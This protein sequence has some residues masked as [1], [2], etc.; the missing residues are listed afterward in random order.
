[1]STIKVNKIEKRT[2]STLTLGGPSTAVTLACGATQTGFG[3][4]GTVDWCTTAKTS[5]LTVESGKGYFINTTSGSVTVTLPSSPSAGDIVAFK[6][7]ANTWDS[8]SLVVCRN[9]SK[10]AGGCI[11][12]SL[13]VE[14]QSVTLIYVDATQGWKDVNDS[15]SNVQGAAFIAATGGTVTTSGNFKIH[16]FN[17]SATFCVSAVGN[18][19]GSTSV[20]YLVVA[21][22]GGGGGGAGPSSVGS[23]GGGAGGYR[24]S[25]GT[26]SGNFCTSPLGSGVSALTVAVQGYPITIGGGGTAGAYGPSAGTPG[27]DGSNSVFSTFTSAGGGGGGARLASPA[28]GRPGGSGGG[29]AFACGSGAGGTGNTPPVSPPQGQ[30]GGDQTGDGAGGGG[31]ATAAGSAGSTPTNGPGGAG[32]TSSI[33]ATPT[34]RAGGGGAGATSTVTTG[35]T[36]SDGGGAGGPASGSATAG[37]TNKGGGGGGASS[38][39]NNAGA[40]GGS[41]VVIIRYRYQ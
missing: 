38:A 17:S 2:G 23:G 1:M 28:N 41:G 39:A 29:T 11:N 10:I 22:G 6:D 25:G 35:G 27:G 15:T 7:Y 14:G 37:T 32:G 40:A 26:A 3:R 12:A 9:G 36:A 30:D 31:G 5:P 34:G 24:E 8:N 19:S 21:G 18:P 4:T 33:N 13:A 20:D 16:T